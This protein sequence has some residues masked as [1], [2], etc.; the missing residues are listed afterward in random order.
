M[1][2]NDMFFI[3]AF[4]MLVLYKEIGEKLDLQELSILLSLNYKKLLK[5]SKQFL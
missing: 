1:V 5:M 2:K 4:S 3:V